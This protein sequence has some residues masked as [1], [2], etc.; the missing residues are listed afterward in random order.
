MTLKK[1]SVAIELRLRAEAEARKVAA[2]KLKVVMLR[3]FTGTVA[4]TTLLVLVSFDVL[5]IAEPVIEEIHG[6]PQLEQLIQDKDFVAVL[7]TARNCRPCE[8]ALKR[9]E[10]IDD[11]AEKFSVDFVKIYDKRLAKQ[12]QI[13]DFPTLTMFRD[14]ELTRF[15]GDI[16]EPD[17]VLEFLTSEDTLTLPDKIE[18]VN[19]ASLMRIIAEDRF[20]TA[21]F[22]DETKESTEVLTELEN[23]DDEADVF[24]IRFVRI[25]D[26]KLAEDFSLAR[27]PS[28]VYFRDGIPIG[29]DTNSAQ[30]FCSLTNFKNYSLPRTFDG[31]S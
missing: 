21:L 30:I 29:I 18:E 1:R 14:G 28:L 24:E 15:Q 27:I 7:W 17:Q 11:D 4:L 5:A 13:T 25:Q 6:A 19:S 22:F 8:L 9:L 3:F 12:Y 23:I 10:T 26:E 20:V 2:Q 16:N 31:R